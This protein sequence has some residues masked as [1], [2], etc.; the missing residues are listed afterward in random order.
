MI[1]K[2]SINTSSNISSVSTLIIVTLL[3]FSISS[4]SSS[5]ANVS[6]SKEGI[7]KVTSKVN[8]E[9]YN[10]NDKEKDKEKFH[11]TLSKEQ[12]LL[13]KDFEKDTSQKS[14]LNKLNTKALKMG[15]DAVPVLTE[16]MKGSK[17]PD[18]SRWMATFLLGKIMG[19]K[20]SN[21]I[22]KFLKHPHWVLRMSALKTLLALKDT[23]FADNFAERLKDESL[24]VRLQALENIR[25]LSINEKAANVWE[26]LYHKQNYRAINGKLKRT[27]II[28]DVI[29]TI[30]ELKYEK[31]KLPL[32]S[33]LK[34]STYD[35]VFDDIDYSLSKITGKSSPTGSKEIKKIYWQKLAL[36]EEST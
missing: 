7:K 29:K 34:K 33:M 19:Q 28:K 8:Y 27:P 35:D 12:F 16:V 17:Y 26:M 4:I 20:S 21:F 24:L 10:D 5:L 14:Y 15:K 2:I 31:A 11:L 32:I 23:R 3:S 22:S 25:Y 13:L 1:K 30:G 18:N 36:E 9:S 6:K